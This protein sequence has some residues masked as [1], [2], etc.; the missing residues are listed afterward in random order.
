MQRK[1]YSQ[2]VQAEVARINRR[3]GQRDAVLQL[4]KG[5]DFVSTTKLAHIAPQYNARIH[6]LR[7]GLHDGYRYVIEAMKQNY[8]RREIDGFVLHGWET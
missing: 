7:R 5:L 1:T 2:K 3:R 8:G 4:L 6:E